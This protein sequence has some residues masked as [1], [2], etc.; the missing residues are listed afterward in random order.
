MELVRA[1]QSV[2]DV[3]ALDQRGTGLST[4]RLDCPD[5][6]VQLPLEQPIDPEAMSDA[7]LRVA[8]ACAEY[9]KAN[10]ADLAGYTTVESVRDLNDLREAL[11]E[12]T[13]NLYGGS[14]GTHLALAAIRLIPEALDR[15]VL[16]GVEGP[17]HTW[18]LPS[19]IEAHF[20]T[21]A[22]AYAA[23]GGKPDSTAD[24]IDRM[25]RGSRPTR[26]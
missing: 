6:S 5:T 19:V 10:G 9:W 7:Y 25:R 1:F 14:Y 11:G 22:R 3:I 16:S 13:I 23:S 17:D 24:L 4:P 8:T 15:V 12:N 21:V 18:K 2:A 20:L 26:P